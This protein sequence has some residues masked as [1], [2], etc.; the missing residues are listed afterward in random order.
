MAF[1]VSDWPSATD[2]RASA[3]ELPSRVGRS[4]RRTPGVIDLKKKATQALKNYLRARPQVLD[5]YVFLDNE[6]EGISDQA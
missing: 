3:M 2:R 1:G 5:G 6:G 4:R